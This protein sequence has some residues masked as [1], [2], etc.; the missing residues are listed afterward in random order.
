MAE[1]FLDFT[2]IRAVGEQMGGKRVTQ[3]VRGDLEAH[4]R[5][6]RVAR[7]QLPNA[8]VRQR[9]PVAIQ[10]QRFAFL[11]TQRGEFRTACIEIC[12]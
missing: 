4:G 8:P 5:F 9:C 2:Q 1:Q 12:F 10:K 7:E 11:G 6:F 3:D